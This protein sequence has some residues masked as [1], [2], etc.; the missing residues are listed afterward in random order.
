MPRRDAHAPAWVAVGAA[1]PCLASI[2][3]ALL[4][5]RVPPALPERG[6]WAKTASFPMHAPVPLAATLPDRP[7]ADAVAL[8]PAGSAG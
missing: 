6:R 7:G 4:A 3:A 5:A 8:P 1:V 2:V